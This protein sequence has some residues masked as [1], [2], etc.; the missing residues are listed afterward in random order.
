MNNLILIFIGGGLGS[1]SRYGI[2][3]AVKNM[4][5]DY[6]PLA[7]FL[8]NFLSCLILALFIVVFYEKA[9]VPTALKFFIITGFCGGFSTFSAFS[10]E[11]SELIRQGNYSVA[12]IN[13]LVNVILCMAVVFYISKNKFPV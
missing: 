4:F 13:I 9:S 3:V 1:I 10:F 12:L 7:T 8:S 2:S 5:K 11:T 6:Y